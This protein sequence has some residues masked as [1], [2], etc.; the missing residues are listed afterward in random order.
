MQRILCQHVAAN[1]TAPS[2]TLTCV[3]PPM[4]PQAAV[5][6]SKSLDAY[7]A[8]MAYVA[9]PYLIDVNL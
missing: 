8:C 7:C 6:P 2:I 4:F 1:Q 3:G 9:L 5:Q